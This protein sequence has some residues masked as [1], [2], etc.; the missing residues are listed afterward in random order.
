MWTHNEAVHDADHRRTRT[1]RGR[2]ALEPPVPS[3][4][5]AAVK[6]RTGHGT[7]TFRT[8]TRMYHPGAA[9]GCD[10]DVDGRV[11]KSDTT[12]YIGEVRRY[13]TRGLDDKHE[14][15]MRGHAQCTSSRERHRQNK[16]EKDRIGERRARYQ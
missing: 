11:G 1:V 5:R 10:E 13:C 14:L 3:C 15:P 9:G 2:T 4:H 8:V 12:Q 6:E 16:A 7:L